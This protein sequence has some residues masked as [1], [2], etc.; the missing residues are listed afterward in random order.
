MTAVYLQVCMLIK[1]VGVVEYPGNITRTYY[2]DM[3]C[4]GHTVFATGKQSS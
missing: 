1:P 2:R 4:G 3:F